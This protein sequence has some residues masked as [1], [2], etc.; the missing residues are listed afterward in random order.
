MRWA[1]IQRCSATPRPRLARSRLP[2][3][4]RPALFLLL[5]SVP[6]QA[7][8]PPKS[9]AAKHTGQRRH[10]LLF[11]FALS[12]CVRVWVWCVVL[13]RREERT[14]I[15]IT[16]Y[17][18]ISQCASS[19]CVWFDS[20]GEN[21]PFGANGKV[22]IHK[23]RQRS[24]VEQPHSYIA[25]RLRPVFRRLFSHNIDAASVCKFVGFGAIIIQCY[26]THTA[27]RTNTHARARTRKSCLA[28]I[29]FIYCFAWHSW[30]ARLFILIISGSRDK[31]FAA[32]KGPLARSLSCL[33]ICVCVRALNS[34]AAAE[35]AGETQQVREPQH[36]EPTQ[37][38]V[39]AAPRQKLRGH[40]DGRKQGA[41]M[42]SDGRRRPKRCERGLYDWGL[43]WL[44]TCNMYDVMRTRLI[45]RDKGRRTDNNSIPNNREYCNKM[46]KKNNGIIFA[47]C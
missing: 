4:L 23:Q 43:F 31:T 1:R 20:F 8:A 27:Q 11:A 38:V 24:L 45:G 41:S 46:K 7:S 34:I 9:Q 25:S 30:R 16:F 35:C 26:F 5:R 3:S 40:Y 39:S 28:C 18:S 37:S 6:P 47:F 19:L 44:A 12:T 32:P 14:F 21:C 29:L 17:P 13:A 22:L 42:V 33:C 2:L 10:F 36:T 15:I